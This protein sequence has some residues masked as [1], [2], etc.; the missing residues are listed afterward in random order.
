VGKVS[1]YSLV[2]LLGVY[3]ECYVKSITK[4]TLFILT[5]TDECFYSL[6]VL[7]L[8]TLYV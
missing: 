3:K 5:P 7:D 8:F 6:K 4:F 1:S 2:L